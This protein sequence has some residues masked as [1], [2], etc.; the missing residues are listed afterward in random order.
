MA[1]YVVLITHEFLK[2]FIAFVLWARKGKRR[3]K[4]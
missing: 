3:K 1:A 2:F 4:S